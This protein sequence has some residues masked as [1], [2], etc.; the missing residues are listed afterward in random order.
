VPSSRQG[1]RRFETIKGDVPSAAN[2]PSGCRFHT[3]CPMAEDICRATPPALRR[4]A[5][6]HDVACHFAEK[7]AANRQKEQANG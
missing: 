3:R 5:P 6:G 1:K 7:V 2:P 4:L